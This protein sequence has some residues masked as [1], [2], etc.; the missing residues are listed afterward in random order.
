M[1]GQQTNEKAIAILVE[2]LGGRVVITEEEWRDVPY[3]TVQ[4]K[5]GE[6]TIEAKRCP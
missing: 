2:R 4:I 3:A 1:D 5:E 6:W